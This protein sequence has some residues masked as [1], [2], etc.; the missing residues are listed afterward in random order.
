MPK[1]YELIRAARELHQAPWDMAG[2]PE[3][4]TAYVWTRWVIDSVSA[5]NHA[6]TERMKRRA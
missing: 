3:T 2:L 6:Q 1:F 4:R 5:E